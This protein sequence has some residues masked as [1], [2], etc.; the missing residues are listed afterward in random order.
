MGEGRWKK[1][2]AAREG[3]K[4][5]A[6]KD[7]RG[8]TKRTWRKGEEEEKDGGQ[9]GRGRERQSPRRRRSQNTTLHTVAQ[10]EELGESQTLSKR[11]E[12]KKEDGN[13]KQELGGKASSG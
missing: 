7:R 13:G 8:D 3:E 9:I 4:E 11:T 2:E 1:Q 6:I 10:V 12:G 5:E